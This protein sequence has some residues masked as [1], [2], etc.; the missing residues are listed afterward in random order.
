MISFVLFQVSFTGI[1]GH[2]A[3]NEGG[4][5]TNYTVD[6]LSLHAKT[7]KKVRQMIE[8]GEVA[9][10]LGDSSYTSYSLAYKSGG[11]MASTQYQA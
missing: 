10:Q 7:M 1:T 8:G 5:R 9:L 4:A 3:F 6:V 2:V 11:S